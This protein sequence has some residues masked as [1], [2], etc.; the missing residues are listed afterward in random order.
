MALE[1]YKDTEAFLQDNRAA[2]ERDPLK[3]NMIWRNV[4]TGKT[5]ET[6]LFAAK[7]FHSGGSLLAIRT[8]HFPMVLYAWGEKLDEMAQTLAAHFAQAGAFPPGVNGA[9]DATAAFARQAV[10]MGAVYRLKHDLDLMCCESPSG[11]P[12]R[13][14]GMAYIRDIDYDLTEYIMGFY[15][16]VKKQITRQEAQ[17]QAE[18]F[19]D[20]DMLLCC[21]DN[22]DVVSIAMMSAPLDMIQA[23]CISL[24]YTPPQYRNQGYATACVNKLVDD[25]FARGNKKVFLYAENPAAIAV[26]KK[27][28]FAPIHRFVEYERVEA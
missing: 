27:I 14:T 1:L 9:P 24:V 10:D 23:M 5:A 18:Q 25:A 17:K 16:D 11:I 7:V 26:Y 28:G 2:L 6:G 20:S 21:V 15:S 22:W 13:D 8:D 12:V 19:K 3:L 4:L